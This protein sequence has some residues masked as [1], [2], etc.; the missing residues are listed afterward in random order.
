MKRASNERGHD[1]TAHFILPHVIHS[2][3]PGANVTHNFILQI[4][5]ELMSLFGCKQLL[6]SL[7]QWL[8]QAGEGVG[9]TSLLT[10]D[11]G[12]ARIFLGQCQGLGL[13]GLHLL[14]SDLHLMLQHLHEECEIKGKT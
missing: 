11:L 8:L 7:L 5:V 4:S 1:N 12:Q 3:S 9:H 2:S 14:L 10:V 6:A 13:Q